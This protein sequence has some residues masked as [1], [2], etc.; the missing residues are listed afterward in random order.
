MEASERCPLWE[1]ESIMGPGA[2]AWASG[3]SQPWAGSCRHSQPEEQTCF[4]RARAH[5]RQPSSPRPGAEQPTFDLD[6]VDEMISAAPPKSEGQPIRGWV[7]R[8]HG[9]HTTKYWLHS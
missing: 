2:S 1:R 8:G 4:L 9:I 3:P 6:K 5:P 7:Q